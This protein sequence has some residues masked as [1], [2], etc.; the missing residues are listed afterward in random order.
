MRNTQSNSDHSDC[1]AK[2]ETERWK[3]NEQM[4]KAV[5]EK[6][7]NTNSEMFWV[8]RICWILVS[9]SKTAFEKT[10]FSQGPKFAAT[11]VKIEDWNP[12]RTFK[13]CLDR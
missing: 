9:F 11:T 6:E 1:L 8:D 4:K 10:I 13:G 2:E 3:R 7:A 12:D 5:L